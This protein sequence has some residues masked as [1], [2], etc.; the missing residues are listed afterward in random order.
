MTLR[1]CLKEPPPQHLLSTA[2]PLANQWLFSPTPLAPAYVPAFL[3]CFCGTASTDYD[4]H[5]SS[6]GCT[7]E[8]AHAPAVSYVK[9]PGMHARRPRS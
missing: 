5:G 6:A 2:E 3:Q 8:C 7:S 1:A 4:K 9:M